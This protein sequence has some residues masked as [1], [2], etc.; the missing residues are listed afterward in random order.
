MFVYNRYKYSNGPVNRYRW[1]LTYS[2]SRLKRFICQET[3][4][5]I[6]GPF[7]LYCDRISS[8]LSEKYFS[9]S[10]LH[11]MT[12]F[13][14]PNTQLHS[15]MYTHRYYIQISRLLIQTV[16]IYSIHMCV[17][18]FL[19]TAHWIF[20]PLKVLHLVC[21]R[22]KIEFVFL[23]IFQFPLNFVVVNQHV[24]SS[25]GTVH[26]NRIYV[27][28]DHE[29]NST[30]GHMSLAQ[31]NKPSIRISLQSNKFLVSNRFTYSF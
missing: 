12:F 6:K 19:L 10:R 18:H 14:C 22:I 16:R 4:T 24:C 3:H 8:F 17:T 15:H 9:L 28:D 2:N 7:P 31:T 23:W 27:D 25:C 13:C 30:T 11:W 1:S 21:S 29:I 20:R 26:R 5:H